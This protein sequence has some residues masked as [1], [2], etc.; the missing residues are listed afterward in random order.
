MVRKG[1]GLVPQLHRKEG[2]IISISRQHNKADGGV[3]A[4]RVELHADTHS[5]NVRL[6]NS[7][8]LPLQ[9]MEILAIQSVGFKLQ[10]ISQCRRCVLQRSSVIPQ[11]LWFLSSGSGMNPDQ[12]QISTQEGQHLTPRPTPCISTELAPCS[13]SGPWAAGCHCSSSGRMEFEASS[14]FHQK[15]KPCLKVIP[16]ASSHTELS[17]RPSS[18]PDAAKWL[19]EAMSTC[20]LRYRFNRRLVGTGQ[21]LTQSLGCSAKQCAC[22]DL[23]SSF[24]FPPTTNKEN[25]HFW[26]FSY[27]ADYPI[28]TVFPDLL[29]EVGAYVPAAVLDIKV[30]NQRAQAVDRQE[31]SYHGSTLSKTHHL[32]GT[33]N[34]CEIHS[35]KC[36]F[37]KGHAPT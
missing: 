1:P 8:W 2:S 25:L 32:P 9:W 26:V 22:L 29:W 5:L 37:R 28:E 20:S 16:H 34:K 15:T 11:I 14:K 13:C 23:S 36:F 3:V 33:P 31:R 19:T 18:S 27:L 6:R 4:P 7:P 30:S 12:L 10:L 21:P 35:L 17:A 24:F